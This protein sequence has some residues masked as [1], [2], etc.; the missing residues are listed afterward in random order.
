M[1]RV[2]SDPQGVIGIRP[3]DAI[4]ESFRTGAGVPF[5]AY[6]L[7]MVCGIAAFNR[8]T[9]VHS[10]GPEWIPAMPDVDATRYRQPRDRAYA[11]DAE[12]SADWPCLSSP[13]R[14]LLLPAQLSQACARQ[15]AGVALSALLQSQHRPFT[16][17]QGTQAI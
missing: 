12:S 6:G 10:I 5:E 3:I 17:V 13:L 16:H 7:D 4:V 15:P 11:R 9:F 14:V 2:Y 8:P 1:V